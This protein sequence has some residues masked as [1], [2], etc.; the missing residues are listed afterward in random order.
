MRITIRDVARKA[1]VSVATVS[2][3]INDS[4]PVHEATRR[5]IQEAARELRYAPNV[6][7]RSLATRRTGTLGVLLPDLHGEFFSEVIRGLDQAARRR[8]HHLLVSSSR[9]ERVEVEAA[10][11]AMRGR[12]DGLVLMSP[13]LDAD[14]LVAALPESL[15]VVLLNCS[16]RD[17]RF[18]SIEIDNFGGARSIVAHLAACGH[19]HIAHIRGAPRNHDAIERLRGYRTAL[20]D[21]GIEPR[22]EWEL[23]GDFSDTAGYEAT[24]AALQLD[25]RPTAIF[26]ANDAMA[27]GALGAIRDAGLRAPD[28]VAVVGFDDV[29]VSRY[30]SPAL[31]TVQVGIHD[32]G[33]Q[34]AGTLLAAV[35]DGAAHRRRHLVLPTR[36]VVRDSCGCRDRPPP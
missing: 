15:P 7:A 16:L 21:A 13:D 31:T 14:T 22:A 1:G 20:R 27:L 29:P 34:A 28:D 2:R 35:A 6:A 23:A 4:G 10:V 24:L 30:V 36:L 11:R 12:V 19:R 8:H 32:L 18:D 25:P 17:D 9:N 3:V 5:R 26:A 33:V